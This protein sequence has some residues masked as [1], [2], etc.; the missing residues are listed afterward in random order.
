MGY[1][2]DELKLWNEYSWH[3]YDARIAATRSCVLELCTTVRKI[4]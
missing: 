1:E 4:K 2:A 3:R